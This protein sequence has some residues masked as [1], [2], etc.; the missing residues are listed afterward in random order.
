MEL[1]F[2][3]M[4]SCTCDSCFGHMLAFIVLSQ[5]WKIDFVQLPGVGC[6]AVLRGTYSE[7]TLRLR[8][9]GEERD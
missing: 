7:A 2:V 1:K 4:N 8:R 5:T 9:K 3:I 6:P